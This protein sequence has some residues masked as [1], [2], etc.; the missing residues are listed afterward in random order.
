MPITEEE[1]HYEL[2]DA[3]VLRVAKVEIE[4][5]KAA[6]TYTGLMLEIEDIGPVS[7]TLNTNE[8]DGRYRLVL[9][10][11][12]SYAPKTVEEIAA[13]GERT[14]TI[15]VAKVPH[16]IALVQALIDREI[17]LSQLIENEL[18]ERVRCDYLKWQMLVDTAARDKTKPK[19]NITEFVYS[20]GEKYYAAYCPNEKAAE[21]KKAL[22]DIF[23][24]EPEEYKK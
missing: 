11:L 12:S 20:Y 4:R 7:A 10:V 17:K 6:G 22:A 18:G 16:D 21:L 1:L 5:M 9:R 24:T 19:K 15:H 8:A 14:S 3:G 23:G 13:G 2:N